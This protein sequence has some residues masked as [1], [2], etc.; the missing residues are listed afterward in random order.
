M[1]DRFL[2]IFCR[3]I[4]GGKMMQKNCCKVKVHAGHAFFSLSAWCFLMSVLCITLDIEVFSFE[5]YAYIRGS[6]AELFRVLWLAVVSAGLVVRMV[7]LQRI[8][9]L[10]SRF[11][12]VGVTLR[13]LLLFVLTVLPPAYEIAAIVKLGMQ[14]KD[15]QH[16]FYEDRE[17]N[18]VALTEAIKDKYY[19]VTD[20]NDDYYIGIATNFGTVS[21]LIR[22]TVSQLYLYHLLDEESEFPVEISLPESFSWKKEHAEDGSAA[23]VCEIAYCSCCQTE[24]TL[25]N[26]V[27]NELDKLS[28]FLE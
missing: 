2:P 26:V 25:G 12:R 4:R 7:I 27:I 10:F 22:T 9:M 8:M 21:L 16:F 13:I 1:S 23:L 18:A 6:V 17:V 20:D 14:R 24:K 5:K 19:A 11:Q 3:L 15:V 28:M